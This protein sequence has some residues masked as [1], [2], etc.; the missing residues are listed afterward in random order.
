MRGWRRWWEDCVILWNRLSSVFSINW[1]TVT[2][3]FGCIIIN[4]SAVAVSTTEAASKRCLSE[5]LVSWLPWD[6]VVNTLYS[7]AHSAKTRCPTVYYSTL[8]YGSSRPNEMAYDLLVS[9][10]LYVETFSGGTEVTVFGR[11]L[12]SVAETRITLTVVVTRFDNTNVTSSL[13]IVVYT[14]N[15]D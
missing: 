8:F 2:D 1:V 7:T 10:I 15:N 6:L 9:W 5:A 14:Q 13:V 4:R 3:G 12:N 11:N